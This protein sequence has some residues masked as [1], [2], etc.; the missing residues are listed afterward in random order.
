MDNFISWTFYSLK[1]NYN[2]SFTYIL[3]NDKVILEYGG[4]AVELQCFPNFKRGGQ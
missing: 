4:G 2:D 1:S 3:Y